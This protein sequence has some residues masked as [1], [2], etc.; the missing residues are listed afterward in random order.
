MVHACPDGQPH[1]GLVGLQG[2]C[3]QVAPLLELLLLE[4]LLLELLLLELLLEE[5]DV[6]AP[7]TLLLQAKVQHSAA[8]RQVAPT[9]LQVWMDVLLL[10]VPWPF[11]PVAV[12]D[13][14]PSPPL[15]P[16]PPW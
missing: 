6:L 10:V 13:P 11:P 1:C 3:E 12:I 9:G 4:L 7:Q 14:P 2:D 16:S 15:P 5:D 8:A